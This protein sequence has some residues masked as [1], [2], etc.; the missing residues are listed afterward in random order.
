[1][2]K[3]LY[4]NTDFY[5]ANIQIYH[6]SNNKQYNQRRGKYKQKRA[7]CHNNSADTASNKQ[8]NSKY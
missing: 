7:E 3:Y 1:M 2:N 8:H 6:I 5:I 4:Y